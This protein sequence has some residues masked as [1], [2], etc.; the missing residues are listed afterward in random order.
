[1]KVE[2]GAIC[3]RTMGNKKNKKQKTKKQQQQKHAQTSEPSA[4]VI[5]CS[6]HKATTKNNTAPQT[7]LSLEHCNRFI[8]SKTH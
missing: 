2:S 3:D 8:S 1:M 7:V 4:N 6:G 5:I